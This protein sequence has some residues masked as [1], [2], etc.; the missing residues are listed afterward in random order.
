MTEKGRLRPSFFCFPQGK[1][2]SSRRG[3][4]VPR[5]RDPC[6]PPFFCFF[7]MCVLGRARRARTIC[8]DW[9]S[10]RRQTCGFSGYAFEKEFH[11]SKNQTFFNKIARKNDRSSPFR[12][13]LFRPGNKK[14]SFYGAENS[15]YHNLSPTSS[16]QNRGAI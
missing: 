6:R 16:L 1:S 3:G 2:A 4:F 13:F 9:Q 10:R 7:P 5:P 12:P 14:C 15:I 8:E 11:L